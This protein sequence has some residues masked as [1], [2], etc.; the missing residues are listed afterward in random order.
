MRT[1][2]RLFRG[3]CTQLRQFLML[4]YHGEADR[5]PLMTPGP[6]RVGALLFRFKALRRLQI[7]FEAF[8]FA[9]MLGYLVATPRE[10]NAAA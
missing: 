5:R 3:M 10:R 7:P 8:D 9:L 2:S 6:S 4:C 1:T